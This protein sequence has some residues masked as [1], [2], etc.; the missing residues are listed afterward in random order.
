MYTY[1]RFTL[2]YKRNRCNIVK[3]LYSKKILK[4]RKIRFTRTQFGK[5][6]RNYTCHGTISQV[7]F[8]LQNNSAGF[9]YSDVLGDSWK[10]VSDIWSAR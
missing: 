10:K 3:Q 4:I 1:N 6:G 5:T 2:L 8:K 9:P 7:V